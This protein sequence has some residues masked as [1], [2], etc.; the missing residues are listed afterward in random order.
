MTDNIK[1]IKNLEDKYG[2]YLFRMALS[3]LVDVGARHL[4]DENVEEGAKQIASNDEETKANS[5]FPIMTAEFQIGIIR[6]AA[7]L[8][9]CS[10]WDVFLYIKEYVDIAKN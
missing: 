5:G 10:V 3:H 7:E 2:S 6:C 1:T 8:A 4:T 9:K